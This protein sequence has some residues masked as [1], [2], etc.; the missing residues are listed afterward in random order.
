VIVTLN[1]EKLQIRECEER[2]EIEVDGQTISVDRVVR[3][4]PKSHPEAYISFLDE[5]GHEIGLLE[6]TEGLDAGSKTLLL[7]RLK[8]LY[9]VPTIQEILEVV[10]SGT[11]SSWRVV[12][13]EGER[14]FQVTGRESLD[15]DKPPVIRVTDSEGQRYQIIDFWMLDGDSRQAIHE[16]LPDKILRS[17]LVARKS[18]GMV[19]R[20]R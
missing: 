4:F 14:S 19:M 17:K 12:T 3:A 6:S 20:M 9:F 2:V 13:D 18:G 8:R 7:D 15:G 5:L 16:L 11:S 10:T 1:P